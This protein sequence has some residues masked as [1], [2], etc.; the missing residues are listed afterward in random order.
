MQQTLF[1]SRAV[2]RGLSYRATRGTG[3]CLLS[4]LRNP[5][6]FFPRIC[7]RSWARRDVLS[8]STR[9]PSFQDM[10]S[11]SR[12]VHSPIVQNIFEL[13]NMSIRTKIQTRAQSW[14]I[15]R[16]SSS[17]HSDFQLMAPPWQRN[18]GRRLLQDVTTPPTRVAEGGKIKSF[19]NKEGQR[20]RKAKAFHRITAS[21]RA[22]AKMAYS[23]FWTPSGVG[24]KVFMR[25][26]ILTSFLRS[27]VSEPYIK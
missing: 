27:I 1:L 9:K 16:Q 20:G 10:V 11:C 5:T 12:F 23:T 24:C 15:G 18:T 13:R 25:A 2:T 26:I 21:L 8:F 19:K 3:P 4:I 14:E 22:W 6:F 17:L 7:T